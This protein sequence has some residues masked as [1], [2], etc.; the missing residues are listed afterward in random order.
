MDI[1]GLALSFLFIIIVLTS[2]ALLAKSNRFSKEFIR[3]FVHI[4]VSNWWFILIATIEKVSYAL[5][6]PILFIVVNTFFVVTKLTKT[7]GIDD[8]KRNLGLIFF[9]LSL[10]ILVGGSYLSYFPIW[11]SGIGWIVMGYGDGLAALI[12]KKYGKISFGHNKSLL[13]S[14]IVLVVSMVTVILFN[15]GYNLQPLS[16]NFLARTLFISIVAM[17]IEAFTPNGLDNF[18]LPI[19]LMLLASYFLGGGS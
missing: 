9:P 19:G 2:G 5:V 13:G 11:A 4:S 3:K 7:I 10:L 6:G 16:V 15:L 1:V 8:E 12:G 18:T 17:L 14:L